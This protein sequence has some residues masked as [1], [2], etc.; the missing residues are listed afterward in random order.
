MNLNQPQK[1]K[2]SLGAL[3]RASK[4]KTLSP[5][6]TGPMKLQRHTFEV[7]AR[8]FEE[9]DGDELACNLA[10]WNHTDGTGRYFSV[11]LSPLYVSRKP[12]VQYQSP[13]PFEFIFGDGEEE[14]TN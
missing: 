8:Q 5:D 3:R 4:T 2:R 13:G 1:S 12:A 6:L 10:A 7:L 14:A 9:T 11:E